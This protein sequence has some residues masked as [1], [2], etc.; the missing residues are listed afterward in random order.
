MKG[1]AMKRFNIVA[2]PVKDLK[3]KKQKS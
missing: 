1:S 2:R 3:I